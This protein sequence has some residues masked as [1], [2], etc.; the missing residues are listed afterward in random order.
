MSEWE[1]T[2]TEFEKLLAETIVGR[3]NRRFKGPVYASKPEEEWKR[4]ALRGQLAQLVAARALNV[5]P[6]MEDGGENWT[7]SYDLLYGQSKIDIKCP[8]RFGGPLR[9]AQRRGEY[10]D[11]YVLAYKRPES[12][13]FLLAGWVWQRDVI[14]P[15]LLKSRGNGPNDSWYEIPGE[16][17]LPMNEI[18]YL[19]MGPKRVIKPMT[20]S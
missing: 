19:F 1:V 4:L 10:A 2:P 9:V 16:E 13:A 17:L 15:A 11:G 8:N 7:A 18:I 20:R 6:N 12:D 14:S 3:M 5:Y